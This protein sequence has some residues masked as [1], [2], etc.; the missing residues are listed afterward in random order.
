MS[1]EVG[2]SSYLIGKTRAN[3]RWQKARARAL[4]GDSAALETS[5]KLISSLE[6]KLTELFYKH[7]LL[8]SGSR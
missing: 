7:S 4:E 5:A 3:L 8:N 1:I 6:A 2:H